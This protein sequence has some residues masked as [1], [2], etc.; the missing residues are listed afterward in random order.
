[1][2]KVRVV[3]SETAMTDVLREV[4]NCV[5]LVAH[6]TRFFIQSMCTLSG[7]GIESANCVVLVMHS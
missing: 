1:M 3:R 6:V 4:S 7:K 5:N 2:M